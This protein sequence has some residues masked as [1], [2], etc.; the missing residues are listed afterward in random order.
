MSIILNAAPLSFDRDTI[1]IGYLP[2]EGKEAYAALREEYRDTHVFRFDRREG[3][4]ANVG[5]AGAAPLGDT[6][7]QRLDEN[8]FLASRVIQSQI[9]SWL[10]G[11]YTVLRRRSP[12]IFWASAQ[13][14]QLLSRA[15]QDVA[16]KRNAE[17][18]PLSGLDVYVRFRL[19]TRLLYPK[20]N[21]PTPYLGLL[22]DLHTSNVMDVPV[23]ELITRGLDPRGMYVGQ[24]SKERD[25]FLLP[26]FETLGRVRDVRDGRLLL[27]DQKQGDGD[28]GGL[29]EQIEARSALVEPRSENLAAAIHTVYGR[30]ARAIGDRLH[31]LRRSYATATGQLGHLVDTLGGL[32]DHVALNVGGATARVGDFL[33]RGDGLFPL[34]ISTSRPTCLFGPQGRK[35]GQHPDDGVSKYGPFQYMLH[36]ANEP[37]VVVVCEASERVRVEQFVDELR[38]GF[39][40]SEWEGATKNAQVR[41]ENPY[42][43][44]LLGKYHLRRVRYEYEEMPDGRPETYRAAIGRVLGRLPRRPDLAIVQTRTEYRGLKGDAN[45]YFV[46][47][48]EFMTKG[49]PVQAVTSEKV[50]AAPR[51][52]P[53][54]L[55]NVGLAS[56]AKLGGTPW[57]ISTRNPSS[58]EVVIGIG[59]TESFERRLGPRKRYVGITTFFQGNGRYLAWDVTREVEFEGYAEALLDS[60]RN[61]IRYVET[62]NEWEPGDRVRLVFHVYKPLKR[63]EIEAVRGVVDDLLQDRYAVEFAFLNLTT[64]HAFRLFDPDKAGVPYYP[65]GRRGKVMKGPGV[66]DRGLCFQLDPRTALLQLVGPRELKTDLDGAPE[67]MLIEIH[68]DSDVD[69]LTYLVRQVFHFSFLSWRSFFPSGEPVTILYSRWIAQRLADLRPV[70]GWDPGA[71]TLGALRGS[72]WFL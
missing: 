26:R 53:Y 30:D 43:G 54:I 11:R 60:L 52:I 23:S 21:E 2:D 68:P 70:T 57:V 31:T 3:L 63:T 15:V 40:T 42:A 51:Q 8:L 72:K 64:F 58:R 25:D 38:D 19:D 6:K 4:I 1:N 5:V 9:V 17:I 62:E 24:R 50:E 39:P 33:E 61:T 27:T 44:G 22:I 7:A 45:P 59:Y 20:G 69:D 12:I 36:E 55:N 65:P 13:R 14:H 56:Y 48:S 10:K 29:A 71:V 32:R 49:V 67:P 35:T 37:L 41:R 28:S 66:P 16:Q 47:K 34:M 46:A 18:S